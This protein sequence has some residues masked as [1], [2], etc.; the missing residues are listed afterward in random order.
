MPRA[1]RAAK[2]GGKSGLIIGIIVVVLIL[3]GL[4]VGGYFYNRSSAVSTATQYM[5]A[6][7]AVFKTGELDTAALK[8]LLV[9][10]QVADVDKAMGSLSDMASDPLAKQ[11]LS[12]VQV[13]Y[14]MGEPEVGMKEGSV[15]VTLTMAIM[16]QSQSVPLKVML[17]REGLAWKVDAEK[18]QSSIPG[19]G[20]AG[21]GAP[22]L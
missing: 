16:G 5:D 19:A 18:T 9:K 8:R 3:A 1:G 4:G 11:F 22:K 7:L 17:V 2:P 21:G 15:A 13:S 20:G 6:G 10:D 14:K 12:Q